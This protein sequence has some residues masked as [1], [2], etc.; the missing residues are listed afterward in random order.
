[1]LLCNRLR[2]CTGACVPNMHLGPHGSTDLCSRQT[3][4]CGVQQ[5][6]KAKSIPDLRLIGHTNHAPF[7]LSTSSASSS[8]ASGGED[9]K[10]LVWNL[11]DYAAAASLGLP[12]SGASTLTRGQCTPGANSCPILICCS[13]GQC[14]TV[15]V[16]LSRSVTSYAA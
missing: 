13:Q 10:V 9:N 1:M 7:A 15:L 2:S 5:K 3:Q 11:D 14:G 12:A 8:I 16:Y 6:G 4:C